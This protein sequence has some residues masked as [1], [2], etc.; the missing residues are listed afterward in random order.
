MTRKTDPSDPLDAFGHIVIVGAMEEEVHPLRRRLEQPR[1]RTFGD[2]TAVS[3]RLGNQPVLV[4]A[5]GDGA[6]AARR[7]L[8]AVFE[9]L[10]VSAL[11]IV[12]VAGGVSPDLEVGRLVVG[13]SVGSESGRFTK[14]DPN[15]LARAERVESVRLGDVLSV[16]QIAVSRDDKLRLWEESNRRPLLVVDLESSTFAELAAEHHVPCLVA[17][18]VSDGHDEDLP[19]DFNQFRTADGGVDRSKVMR[20]AIC[21]PSLMP[22]L[23]KLRDRV[24]SGAADL[25]RFVEEVLAQ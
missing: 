11:V 20:Q 10:D 3:G 7:G 25:C 17:R 19:L 15:L 13:R 4:V 14:M 12:G 6:G 21:H 1:Q 23:L 16:G 9:S 8:S 2:Q 24:R 22:K 5:T 18:V